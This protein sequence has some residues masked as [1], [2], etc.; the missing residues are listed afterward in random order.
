MQMNY[1]KQSVLKLKAY[2]LPACSAFTLRMHLHVAHSSTP[3]VRSG[4]VFSVLLSPSVHLLRWV[5]RSGEGP[6]ITSPFSWDFAVEEGRKK[7]SGGGARQ[8][9]EWLS[10]L[11]IHSW[12]HTHTPP[13]VSNDCKLFSLH[14]FVARNWLQAPVFLC[15]RAGFHQVQN[16]RTADSV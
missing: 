4:T 16:G 2:Y 1:M 10:F 7:R 12:S 5:V 14:L 15:A 3:F 11:H 9:S 13:A 6:Y 8:R